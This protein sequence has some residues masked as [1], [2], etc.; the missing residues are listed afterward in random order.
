MACSCIS[1]DFSINKGCI[2]WSSR[3]V[4]RSSNFL[5][6]RPSLLITVGVLCHL[7]EDF[8]LCRIPK[9]KFFLKSNSILKVLRIS[10]KYYLHQSMLCC[11]KYLEKLLKFDYKSFSWICK[12]S[13]SLKGISCIDSKT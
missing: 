5:F 10:C 2:I 13:I 12:K 4:N 1:G 3:S 8:V 7:K 9:I 6:C 11:S